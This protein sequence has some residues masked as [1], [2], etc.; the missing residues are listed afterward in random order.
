MRRALTGDRNVDF[1]TVGGV[2]RQ[3]DAAGV[4]IDRQ[5]AC[6]GDRVGGPVAGTNV[7]EPRAAHRAGHVDDR[8]GRIGERPFAADRA[9]AARPS[10]RAAGNAANRGRLERGSGRGMP[11]RNAC[12]DE[13]PHEKPDACGHTTLH[14][15]R[16]PTGKVALTKRSVYHA[17]YGRGLRFQIHRTQMARPLGARRHLSR[18]RSTTH[19][20]NITCCE[21]LPY[22]S[23]DLHVGHAKNYTLGDAIARMMRMLGYNVLH[24]MGLGRVRTSGR[25]RGDRTRHPSGSLDAPRTSRTWSGKCASWAR[26]TIGRAKSPPASPSTTDWNQWL[27]LRLYE[28]GLAYKREA[29]VNWCPHDKTVLA[30][31]QVDRRALLA[32]PASRRAAQPFAV[33]SQ[34]H[35]LRRAAA[36]RSRQA[37]RLARAHVDDAAQLDRPQRRRA[38]RDS[39]SRS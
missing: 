11:K 21:M 31:E 13:R 1:V 2:R 26:A 32:L 27:F 3:I 8:I 20:R 33:V 19:A 16:V 22:P 30:N 4:G 29:P 36:R 14:H 6:A 37:R 18:E 35:G 34:D 15:A 38:V 12:Q 10:I 9:A 24:P 25:K 17:G 23:G 5:T 7:I 28:R 39:A